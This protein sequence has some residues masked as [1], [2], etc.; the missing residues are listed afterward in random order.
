MITKNG[1][2]LLIAILGFVF[3]FCGNVLGQNEAAYLIEQ[4]IELKKGWNSVC[5]EVT[6]P[7][8]DIEDIFAELPVDK[9]A[10]FLRPVLPVEFIT[11]P[12]EQSWKRDEWRVWYGP[13]TPEA[14][15]T[16]LHSVYAN[17]PLLVHATQDMTFKVKGVAEPIE[18]NWL[19][20]S[21]NLVNLP[22]DPQS[23]PTFA[24]YFANSPAHSPLLAYR[25]DQGKWRRIQNPNSELVK[26]GE[27]V[28]VHCK[29]PSKH[30]GPLTLSLPEG[31]GLIMT[32]SSPTKNLVF[33]NN[34]AD[35][36][37]VT[38]T[39]F[40]PELPVTVKYFVIANDGLKTF[41]LPVGSA[42]GLPVLESRESLTVSL[43]LRA[44][45]ASDET[46]AT[47]LEVRS[48]T[49]IL[50]RVPVLAPAQ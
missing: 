23:P 28:W 18:S 44:D 16:N 15:L 32:S 49:G 48:D 5:L 47:L 10:A 40:G 12:D 2:V 35:P 36:A 7:E 39:G 38:I 46:R 42:L 33:Q 9:V 37:E 29:G 17:Q 3:H 24:Q 31:G 19:P 22:A 25:L 20:D 21:F 27:A 26:R 4:D 13:R 50:Q 1:N 11:D 6:P 41:Q 14:P 45:Q 30:Q 8:P 34:G 43:K